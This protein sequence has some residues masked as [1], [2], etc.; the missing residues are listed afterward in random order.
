MLLC[1]WGLQTAKFPIGQMDIKK[2][3]I[4]DSLVATET[5]F[6]F[7]CGHR[8]PSG[9][10]Q[11]QF[12]LDSKTVFLWGAYPPKTP[13]GEWHMRLSMWSQ[14]WIQN[15]TYQ[16]ARSLLYRDL[17]ASQ[18]SIHRSRDGVRLCFC[19]SAGHL[20][21]GLTVNHT[22][23]HE[24]SA[25]TGWGKSRRAL[26]FLPNASPLRRLREVVCHVF[27]QV[28]FNRPRKRGERRWLTWDVCH[29]GSKK[30]GA[31]GDGAWCQ[32]DLCNKLYGPPQTKK[33]KDTADRQ[34]QYI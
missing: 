10:V 21:L 12:L 25:W 7:Q 17:P 20:S 8:G 22:V 3:E 4:D 30:V 33:H 28:K 5:F 6:L 34:K 31:C 32:S 1:A 26:S 15:R 2:I 23:V 16:D 27:L 14:S 9:L 13:I 18:I 11:V 24:R 19:G 29:D